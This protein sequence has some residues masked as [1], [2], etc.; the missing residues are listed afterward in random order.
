MRVYSDF[1][2]DCYNSSGPGT[3]NNDPWIRLSKFPVSHTNNKFTAIGCDTY[4]LIKGL[5][6][7]HTQLGACL[8]VIQSVTG[9]RGLALALVVARLLFRRESWITKSMSC[10]YSNH[11]NV[12]EFNPCSYDFGAEEET[13]NFSSKDLKDFTKRHEKTQVVLNWAIGN[14]TCSES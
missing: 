3:Y 7:Q 1:A 6:G 2:Q 8:H 10:S 13:H 9:L 4:A 5:E 14:Q 12:Y 11:T